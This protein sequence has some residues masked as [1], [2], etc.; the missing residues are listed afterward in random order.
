VILTVDIGNSH[1]VLGV[2]E[3]DKLLHNWRI[4]T[5]PA[6]TAEE[7]R[8]I[9]D[10]FFSA[11]EPNCED[12][13]GLALSSVVPDTVQPFRRMAESFLQRDPLI[14]GPGVKTGMNIRMENPRE[15]GSDRIVIAV[16]AYQKFKSSAIVVDFG[17]ATTISAVSEDGDYLGGAI[18]PGISIA[19]EALFD[20]AAKLPRI[21]VDSPRQVIGKNTAEALRSGIIYGFTAQ[22]EGLVHRFQQEMQQ[23]RSQH[24]IQYPEQQTKLY[25]EEQPEQQIELQEI[26]QQRNQE[27][28]QQHNSQQQKQHDSSDNPDNSS[29]RR[30][31]KS[32]GCKTELQQPEEKK[33]KPARPLVIATGGLHGYIVPETDI[34]DRIEPHLSLEGLYHIACLN[35]IG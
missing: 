19:T 29:D 4:T 21:E 12:L 25:S 24:K 14:I 5:R 15:V 16:G 1:T 27:N 11:I 13:T 31:E 18:A 2:H 22:V 23:K 26:Q 7:Y 3:D 32:P 33:D 20:R 17:T 34:F 9:I 8:V 30:Q 10:Q 28:Q 35:K 6:C